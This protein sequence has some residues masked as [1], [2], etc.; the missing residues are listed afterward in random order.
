MTKHNHIN[1][2][3]IPFWVDKWL[4]GSTRLELQ[5]DERS[6][7]LDL[8]ALASKNEGYIRANENMPY[9]DSQ[10]AGLLVISIELLQR[11]LEKC[12]QYDKITKEENGTYYIDNW[13][14]YQLSGRHK[15]R[16]KEKKSRVKKSIEEKSIEEKRVSKKADIMSDKADI[17]ND[18]N[19]KKGKAPTSQMIAIFKEEFANYREG[20]P[21]IDAGKDGSICR[22]LWFECLAGRPDAPID[23]WR[24][25][26]GVLIKERDISSIGGISAFWN[27]AIPK[28]KGR[29]SWEIAKERTQQLLKKDKQ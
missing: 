19:I 18:M 29:E 10:L 26:C 15:R 5:P 7:W 17:M 1:K 12:I 6:V 27:T 14:K 20:S 13:E 2:Y 4:F 28:K 3:W 22:R 9:A 24:E 25:R 23:M 11:T 21:K 8:L 16:F